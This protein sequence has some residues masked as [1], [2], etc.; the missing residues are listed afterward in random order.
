MKTYY[1]KT[2]DIPSLK[3]ALGRMIE[4]AIFMAEESGSQDRIDFINN[5]LNDDGI[6]VEVEE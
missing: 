6:E 1:V 5:I 4:F 2:N 3:D